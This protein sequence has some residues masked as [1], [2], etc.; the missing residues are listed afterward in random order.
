MVSSDN[1]QENPYPRYRFQL[2]F[3]ASG[4][5]RNSSQ[6]NMTQQQPGAGEEEQA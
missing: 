3:C 2:P 1:G 6:L 4:S 5:S